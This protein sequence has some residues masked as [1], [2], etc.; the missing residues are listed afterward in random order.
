MIRRPPRS[1]RTDT[2]FPYTTLFRSIGGVGVIEDMNKAV[3]IGFKRTGDIVLAVG[4]RAGH[5]GQSVWLR[6]ILGREEGPPHPVDLR[7]EKR[8]GDFI[9]G[10]TH[11][12][13]IHA[14]HAVADG[15]LAGTL[16]EIIRKRSVRGKGG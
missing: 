5:L 3:G 4:E 14:C 16:P 13:W 1:T 11:A 6:E 8:P 7:A 10:A 12:G 15:G 2:L 9:R